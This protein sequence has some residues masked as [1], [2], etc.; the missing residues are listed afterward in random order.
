MVPGCSLGSSSD[1][2]GG[3]RKLSTI[4]TAAAST[5]SRAVDLIRPRMLNQ[6]PP[7]TPAAKPKNL[8]E[9]MLHA[10]S[11]KTE[12]GLYQT[13]GTNIDQYENQTGQRDRNQSGK[14]RYAEDEF[15]A[16]SNLASNTVSGSP[17]PVPDIVGEIR[18]RC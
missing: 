2:S 10:D 3:T 17:T 5:S 1:S 13:S 7:D 18:A 15:P 4:P 14:S 8:L 9:S 6:P 12:N 11:A 16:W